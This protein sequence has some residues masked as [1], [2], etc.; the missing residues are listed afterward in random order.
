[1]QNKFLS[2]NHLALKVI[3]TKPGFVFVHME[4]LFFLKQIYCFQNDV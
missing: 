1:M 4:M 2:V 3:E